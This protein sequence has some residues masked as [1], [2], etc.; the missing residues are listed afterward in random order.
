MTEK[1]NTFWNQVQNRNG[2]TKYS[3][4]IQQIHEVAHV[5]LTQFSEVLFC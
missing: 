1:N 5:K 3:Y 4:K 2:E